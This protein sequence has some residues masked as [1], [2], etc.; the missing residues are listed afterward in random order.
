MKIT[1][2][3]S[4]LSDAVKVLSQALNKKNALPILGDF[5]CE[6][7]DKELTITAS[8]SEVTIQQTVELAESAPAGKFCVSATK[9]KDSLVGISEQPITL[10]AQVENNTFNVIHA[11]GETHFAITSPL[12]DEYPMPAQQQYKYN[13]TVGSIDVINAINRCLWNVANDELR[14][15][16]CGVYFDIDGDGLTIVGSDGRSIVKTVLYVGADFKASFILP[17][18]A[19]QILTKIQK[20]V[21]LKIS[22]NKLWVEIEAGTIK[23]HS[24]L[25]EGN[26]PK[27]N[28]VF[29]NQV[30]CVYQAKL[31]RLNLMNIVNRII[32]FTFE[33]DAAASVAFSFGCDADNKLQVRGDDYDSSMGASETTFIEEWEGD[34]LSIGLGGNRLLQLL[35]NINGMHVIFYLFGPDK[36]VVIKEAD[37]AEDAPEVTML[38]M[39][40]LLN[41]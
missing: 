5:H 13:L 35:K 12:A 15:V 3:K 10:D 29:P 18:K 21:D 7:S 26:Y 16:M 38:V 19:A 37:P 33:Y 6:V 11:N 32:P 34:P 8:D 36:A 2:S 22:F 20:G 23:L 9:L 40:V 41:D 17:K 30:E 39:P 1:L 25:I 24:R 31:H 14:P 28:S 27:Y 4:V